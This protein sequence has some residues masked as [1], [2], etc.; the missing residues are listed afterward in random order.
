EYYAEVDEIPW[1][2]A[3]E[4]V[5]E[6]VK[7]HLTGE[8]VVS[9]EQIAEDLREFCRPAPEFWAHCGA[10]DWVVINQLYGP[11]VDHPISWKFWCN[12]VDQYSMQLGI[13]RQ[14]WPIQFSTEHNALEDARWTK[15]VFESLKR[16]E[17]AL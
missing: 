9:K 17:D 16:K 8:Y 7:P 1:E 10:Y 14:W 13:P 15:E 4:W 5:L 11:M 12:D 3:S 6:N 2:T